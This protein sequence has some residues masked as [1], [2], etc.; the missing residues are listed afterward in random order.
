MGEE[1]KKD[2]Q[3]ERIFFFF[4]KY[5]DFFSKPLSRS[6]PAEERTV[7]FTKVVVFPVRILISP[8]QM[9]WL[10]GSM[11]LVSNTDALFST[12]Q[13]QGST[14]AVAGLF[15]FLSVNRIFLQS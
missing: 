8:S 3:K 13:Q 1:R 7:V 6:I 9:D 14:I 4:L 5:T 12:F 10:A 11:M 15:F 2:R